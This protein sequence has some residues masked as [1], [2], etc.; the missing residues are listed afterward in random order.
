[1]LA[2]D[3]RLLGPD[4]RAIAAIPISASRPRPSASW[5]AGSRSRRRG[6]AAGRWARWACCAS[7]LTASIPDASGARALSG[8]SLP[9]AWR[10]PMSTARRNESRIPRGLYRCRPG[11]DAEPCH[12]PLDHS[13]YQR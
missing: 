8:R 11:V 6:G 13:G 9:G 2:V 1:V 4:G 3:D 5:R 12:S 7:P 10:L